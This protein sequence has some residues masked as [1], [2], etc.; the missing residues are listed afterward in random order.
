MKSKNKMAAV[1][2]FFLV[3]SATIINVETIS[4]FYNTFAFARD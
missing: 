3:E 2:Q 4:R 1:F